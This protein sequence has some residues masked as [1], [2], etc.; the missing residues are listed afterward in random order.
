MF[1]MTGK[2][3]IGLVGVPLLLLIIGGGVILWVVVPEIYIGQIWVGVGV[4]LALVF[5]G[6]LRKSN[7]TKRIAREGIPGT[8]RVLEMTETGTHVN[9]RP[10]IKVRLQVEAPGIA[11]FEVSRRLVVPY[12]S[13]TALSSGTIPVIVDRKDHSKVVVDYARISG[14]GAASSMGRDPAGVAP[15]GTTTEARLATL[16]ELRDKDLISAEEYEAKRDEILD[17]I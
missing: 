12:T 1:S 14:S 13:L 5:G 17:S 7:E 9:K 4:L 15:G 10:L 8:G 11:P 2:G 6:L 3:I 16:D